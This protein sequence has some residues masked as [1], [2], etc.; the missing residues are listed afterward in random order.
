MT[1]IYTKWCPS[2]QRLKIWNDKDIHFN[3]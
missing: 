2:V 1:I 3:T